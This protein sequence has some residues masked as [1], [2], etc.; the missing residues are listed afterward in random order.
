[1]TGLN[2]KNGSTEAR[3]KK[4]KK[5]RSDKAEN[6]FHAR[7]HVLF[8]FSS[9]SSHLP[10][11][12]LTYFNSFFFISYMKANEENCSKKKICSRPRHDRT[13]SFFHIHILFTVIELCA[14][15]HVTVALL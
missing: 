5:K 13:K 9:S 7:V 6:L 4:I 2:K 11:F 14:A 10:L 15:F 1:M 8:L 3:K 12:L